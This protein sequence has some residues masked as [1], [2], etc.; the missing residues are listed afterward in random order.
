MNSNFQW[1]F[2]EKKICLFLKQM[3]YLN[4]SMEQI[5]TFDDKIIEIPECSICLQ[6]LQKDLSILVN[7]GHVFHQ[8]CIYYLK[9]SAYNKCPICRVKMNK[10][11][12]IFYSLKIKP[13]EDE[14]KFMT[15][16]IQIINL[17]EE[18]E[19]LKQTRDNDK[20][21][22]LILEQMVSTRDKKIQ[23]L[24]K[25]YRSSRIEIQQIKDKYQD[26]KS[27]FQDLKILSQNF[28]NGLNKLNYKLESSTSTS[29]DDE[30]ISNSSNESNE[31]NNMKDQFKDKVCQMIQR[32]L[33]QQQTQQLLK[34]KKQKEKNQ[35][36]LGSR[37]QK[38]LCIKE[39]Q[40]FEKSLRQYK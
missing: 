26:L 25:K 27:D 4:L 19:K 39:I 40:S 33:K 35:S 30:E 36:G 10:R 11:C 12:D 23:I 3:C 29:D 6:S 5:S 13:I 17:K 20:E 18:I 21:S 2:C 9:A 16:M 24:Q 22:L 14:P 38:K 34:D 32:F 28:R 8:Q 15:N 1:V 7:C 31:S 37:S